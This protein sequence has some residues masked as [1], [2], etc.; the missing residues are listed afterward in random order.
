M[1][2][3]AIL[4]AR[5]SSSRLPGKVLMPLAGQPILLRQIERLRRCRLVDRLVVATSVDL[6]DDELAG[7][8]QASGI[9]C[10]RGNLH[11][12]LDRY[13]TA[14]RTLNPTSVVRLTADCPMADPDVV[15]TVI[16]TFLSTGCDY[17]SNTLQPTFPDGLDV[18]VMKADALLSAWREAT[19][20][21]DREHVT[22]YIYRNA[23]RFS[24]A[25]VSRDPNLSGHRWTLDTAADLEFIRKVYGALYSKKPAFSM[26]DVLSLL[27]NSQEFAD[28]TPGPIREGPVA[29]VDTI[30]LR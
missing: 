4:Q 30:F 6:S 27:Q 9:E 26:A 8:C 3:V 24:L 5:Q 28:Y 11:D 25:N 29:N 10:V 15:D 18:E 22:P 17:V 2:C 7:V 13:Y 19:A 20:Q 23:S 14:I 12:V 21:Y 16:D 1:T